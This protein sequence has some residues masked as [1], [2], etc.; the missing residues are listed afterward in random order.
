VIL[1][2]LRE[3][4]KIQ[5]VKNATAQTLRLKERAQVGAGINTGFY[6]RCRFEENLKQ[7]RSKIIQAILQIE[8]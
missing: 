6:Q 7:R 4:L 8:E 5:R 1:K 3:L 2:E